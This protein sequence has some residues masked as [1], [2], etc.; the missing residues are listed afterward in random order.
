M[1]KKAVAA[2]KF[3]AV[4]EAA[5]CS[6]GHVHDMVT[7]RRPVSDKALEYLGLERVVTYRRRKTRQ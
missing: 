5:G 6:V 7:G 4:A 2:H 3:A 1:L